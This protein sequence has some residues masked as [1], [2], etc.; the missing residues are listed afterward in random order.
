M[1]CGGLRVTRVSG[2]RRAAGRARDGKGGPRRTVVGSGSGLA[3]KEREGEALVRALACGACGV[4]ETGLRRCLRGAV[5]S[6]PYVPCALTL[7]GWTGGRE[8]LGGTHLMSKW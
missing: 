4:C 7:K 2:L 6:M 3:H 1:C 5:R 8:G